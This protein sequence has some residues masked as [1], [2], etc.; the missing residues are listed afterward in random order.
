MTTENKAEH[1]LKAIEAFNKEQSKE[2]FVETVKLLYS[3]TVLVPMKDKAT[4]QPDI[5]MNPSEET[6]FPAFISEDEVPEEYGK[7]KTLE[8]MTFAAVIEMALCYG[9]SGVLV[10]PFTTQFYLDEGMYIKTEA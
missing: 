3:A 1:I 9:T 6:A 4:L 2:N 5:L 10:D 7:N 8:P